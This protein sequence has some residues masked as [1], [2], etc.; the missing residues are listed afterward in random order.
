[1]K[2]KHLLVISVDAMVFEDI[3]YVK[4]LPNFK[5]LLDGCAMIERVKTIYPSLTHPVHATMITG[6]PAGITGIA[7]NEYFEPGVIGGRWYNELPE[8]GCETIFHAAHRAGLTS[9]VTTW[10]V[11]NKGDGV[12]DHLVPCMMN[13]YFDGRDGDPIIDVCREMGATD[14]VDEILRDTIDR[15]G[16]EN[17]HPIIEEFQAYATARVIKELK[18]NLIFTHPSYVDSMRHSGGVFSE[19]VN[20]ALYETDRWL[21]MMLDAL[22]EAGIADTT[23]VV[24]LSDHGQVDIVR[25]V[26]LN[27]LL[28]DKGYITVNGDGEVTDWRVYVASRGASAHVFLKDKNDTALYN[29]VRALLDELKRQGVWGF[30]EVL[31]REEVK[32][33]YGLD[34]EFSFVL[35]TDGFTS[36]G[37]EWTYPYVR[38]LCNTDYRF[39]RATHG[40]KPE[41]GAQPTFIAKGPSFRKGAI[42]PEGSILG[43]APTFAKIFGLTLKDATGVPHDEI[44][45]I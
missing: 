5:R 27:A 17:A 3:E 34:G 39:G 22:D 12:I 31:T 43:H 26:C 24:V 44:L 10:P 41:K 32:A 38:P 8:I 29:E 20:L 15:F 1:M 28:R 36:F 45:N 33:E 18:P 23:D 9:A 4:E 6:A 13:Y 35:E 14:S 30:D 25:R 37:E 21:G 42:I 19:K 7:S 2:N 40:H 11:T 16:I